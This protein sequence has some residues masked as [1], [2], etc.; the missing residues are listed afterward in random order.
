[1]QGRFGD[2]WHFRHEDKPSRRLAMQGMAVLAALAGLWMAGCGGSEG[3][4]TIPVS[5]KVTLNGEP[6]T[7]GE[8]AFVPKEGDGTRRPG[9]GRI[10]EDGTFVL[11]SH[12][13]EG[14]EPGDYKVVVYPVA[15]DDGGEKKDAATISPIPEKYRKTETT[16][17]EA[18]VDASTKDEELAFD[19]K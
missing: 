3:P 18:T 10:E 1:M 19:L 15:S 11:M 9:I 2:E 14:V 4:S 5:G 17:L 12:S 8:V 6:L 16:D 13:K 7:S